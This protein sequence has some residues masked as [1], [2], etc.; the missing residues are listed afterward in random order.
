MGAAVGVLALLLALHSCARASPLAQRLCS[1]ALLAA[2]LV[3]VPV[4]L[5]AFSLPAI[6]LALAAAGY[7]LAALARL[8]F[9]L[10]GRAPYTAVLA[11]RAYDFLCGGILLALCCALA[12]PDFVGRVQT[13]AL[14]SSAFERG[15]TH[16]EMSRLLLDAQK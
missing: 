16:A 12:L 15:V 6:A 8:A 7:L 3:A 11:M 4:V 13:R 5:R 9:V 10:L 14:L 1:V 2:T